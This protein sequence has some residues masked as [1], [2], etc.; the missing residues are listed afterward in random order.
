[1]EKDLLREDI[2][3]AKR[4]RYSIIYDPEDITVFFS[5]VRIEEENGGFYLKALY[6]GKTQVCE[7]VFPLDAERFGRGDLPLK[8]L[9]AKYCSYLRMS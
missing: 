5:G 3:G 7:R 6:K 9:L 8:N 2:P 1:M 4:P